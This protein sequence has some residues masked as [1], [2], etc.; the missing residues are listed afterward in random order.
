MAAVAG[1]C[2]RERASQLNP[3]T[4]QRSDAIDI[5]QSVLVLV[6]YQARLLPAIH[7]GEQSVAVAQALADAARAVG[8]RVIGTEQ[9]AQGLGPNVDG[10]KRRCDGTLA[11]LHFDACT[12]GLGNEIDAHG[13]R[14]HVVLAGCEAHVCLMQ[15][16][17]GL[18]RQGRRVWVVEAACGS[19][20]AE[21]H[22]LAMQRL[23][24]AGATIVAP[25]MV[26]FEWLGSS[27]HPKFRAVLAIVK[28]ID[29]R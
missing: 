26:L 4:A 24:K 18:L 11:K 23:E 27:D 6:D 10:V 19:R 15:T 28:A 14:K 20:R 16:G 25:E 8:V 29:L 21:D 22:Q 17:L 3:A 9:N 2:R 13:P 5:A 1:S 7:R 12:D